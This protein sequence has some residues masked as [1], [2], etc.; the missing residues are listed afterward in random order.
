[1]NKLKFSAVVYI[2]LQV[3]CGVLI[4]AVILI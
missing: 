1:M 4:I 3:A 2:A